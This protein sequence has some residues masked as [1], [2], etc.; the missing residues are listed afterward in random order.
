MVNILI[1]GASG[2]LAQHLFGAFGQH[3]VILSGISRKSL[4][5]KDLEFKNIQYIQYNLSKLAEVFMD[6]KPNIII[7][8]AANI[9]LLRCEKNVVVAYEANLK[10]PETIVNA[11]ELANLNKKPLLVQI[12]T[13]N[14]Y[15]SLGY[16][17]EKDVSCLNNYAITKYMGEVPVLNYSRGIVF[18]TNYLGKGIS[19]S[20]YFDWVLDSILSDASVNVYS[21]VFFNP[22]AP[23][24][25]AD[26]I[27]H[28]YS[29]N[30]TG[31]FNLGGEQI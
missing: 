27:I 21:D 29:N 1:L 7:N 2:N 14:L 30:L 9:D 31:C 26:N 12:S 15:N 25:I 23:K 8:C 19:K 13:D 3:K 4:N 6:Y 24:N 28:A 18:R 10:L 20:S 22:T 11:I 17:S 5:K 16:S